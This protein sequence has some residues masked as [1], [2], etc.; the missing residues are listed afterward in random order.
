MLRCGNFGIWNTN[1]NYAH[2]APPVGPDV[3]QILE[4]INSIQ[5]QMSLFLPFLLDFGEEMNT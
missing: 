4:T 3:S 5:I 1:F 2:S